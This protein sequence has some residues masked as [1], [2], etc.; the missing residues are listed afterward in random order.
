[1]IAAKRFLTTFDETD[2]FIIV[3]DGNI[4]LVLLGSEKC[5]FIYNR[6]RYLIGVK[7]DITYIISD[8]YA[9]LIYSNSLPLEKT[10]TFFNLTILIK[11]GIKE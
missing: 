2:R 5:G 8:N 6:I 1:M 10:M 7:S 11:P 4:Y 9:K 3:Y